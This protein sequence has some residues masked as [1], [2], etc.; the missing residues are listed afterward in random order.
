MSEKKTKKKK[1]LVCIL[2]KSGSNT[3][4]VQHM[5]A[6]VDERKSAPAIKCA[7]N[8]DGR[9]FLSSYISLSVNRC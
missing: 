7:M 8:V 6:R 9:S 1:K 5:Y 3:E 2:A 4:Y